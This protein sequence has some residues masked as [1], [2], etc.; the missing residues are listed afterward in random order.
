MSSANMAAIL[1]R[2][3]CVN[4]MVGAGAGMDENIK[5]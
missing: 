2:W 4:E 1:S 5:K 3:R